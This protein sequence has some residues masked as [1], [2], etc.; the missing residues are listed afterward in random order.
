MRERDTKTHI[1][2]LTSNLYKK[3]VALMIRRR[4]LAQDLARRGLKPSF[5]T[6][7]HP[8]SVLT[9]MGG[10]AGALYRNVNLPHWQQAPDC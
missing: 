8:C 6:A 7:R 2:V 10:V 9:W 5:Q 3:T 4:A 1:R